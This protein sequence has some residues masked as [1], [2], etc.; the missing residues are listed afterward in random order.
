MLCSIAQPFAIF[1]R[2]RPPLRP[3]A[4]ELAVL[5]SLRAA[6]HGSEL[7][8]HPTP[9]TRDALR[10]RRYI[11]VCIKLRPVQAKSCRADFN[12]GKLLGR[13]ARQAFR[14]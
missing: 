4:R 12:G 6:S 7:C 2:G 14:K 9:G 8:R 5:V 3:L 13:G 10:Q 11:Q 1:V